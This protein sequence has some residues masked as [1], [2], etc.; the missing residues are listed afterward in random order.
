M[1]DKMELVNLP[2]DLPSAYSVY[3]GYCDACEHLHLVLENEA[4]EPIAQC[5]LSDNMLRK[6]SAHYMAK[7]TA[8]MQR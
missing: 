1:T 7:L 3:I 5:V 6:L 2:D 8:A 4:G